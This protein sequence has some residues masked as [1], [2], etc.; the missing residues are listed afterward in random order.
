MAIDL[1]GSRFYMQQIECGARKNVRLKADI[2][3]DIDAITGLVLP[4]LINVTKPTLE[5]LYDALRLQKR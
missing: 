1:Q 3:A 4:S 2:V 5:K